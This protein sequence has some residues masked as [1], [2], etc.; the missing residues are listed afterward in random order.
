MKAVLKEIMEELEG[1][2]WFLAK[3]VLGAIV[4]LI[5]IMATVFAVAYF[6]L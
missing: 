1:T 6:F 3:T 2:I 4:G 5:G